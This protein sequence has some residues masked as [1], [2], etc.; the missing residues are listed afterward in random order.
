M[1]KSPWITQELQRPLLCVLSF[2]L[3]LGPNAACCFGFPLSES[4]LET[5]YLRFISSG[6]DLDLDT[7]PQRQER[8]DTDTRTPTTVLEQRIHGERER[9][10]YMSHTS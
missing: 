8:K 5:N 6:L 9:E 4:H 3:L 1:N 7:P 10:K 2:V